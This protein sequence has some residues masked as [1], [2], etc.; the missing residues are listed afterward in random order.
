MQFTFLI[1]PI[2]FFA[3]TTQTNENSESIPNSKVDSTYFIPADSSSVILDTSYSGY[4]I[5]TTL[6]PIKGKYLCGSYASFD[7][8]NVEKKCYRDYELQIQIEN[9]DGF[10]V[11][12]HVSKIDFQSILKERTPRIGDRYFMRKVKYAGFDN[13]EFRFDLIILTELYDTEEDPKALIKCF[14]SLDNKLRFEDYPQSY[15]DS[16]KTERERPK[17]K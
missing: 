17:D 7:N 16:L 8:D 9:K 1:L 15:Y 12:K 4:A 5:K 14:I 2:L 6:S 11:D 10:S 13:N 3:C